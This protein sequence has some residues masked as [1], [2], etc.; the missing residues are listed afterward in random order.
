MK[1]I[2]KY[3]TSDGKLFN[4]EKEA[5]IHAKQR[6]QTHME[7]TARRMFRTISDR[8][9]QTSTPL[10]EFLDEP[11]NIDALLHLFELRRDLHELHTLNPDET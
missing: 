9:V 8:P 10:C 1:Q 6:Y 11:E 7:H 3:Q 4:T 5:R 2:I